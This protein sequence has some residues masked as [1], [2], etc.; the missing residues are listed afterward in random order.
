MNQTT[1]KY[2][3]LQC[4]EMDDLSFV[5]S[6]SSSFD[7]LLKDLLHQKEVAC[8]AVLNLRGQV[9]FSN[10]NH[11]HHKMPKGK[12]DALFS[13]YEGRALVTAVKEGV[14]H[15][16]TLSCVGLRF[17]I[18]GGG[19]SEVWAVGPRRAIG[20]Y[21]RAFASFH[22]VVLFRTQAHCHLMLPVLDKFSRERLLGGM[23]C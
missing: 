19:P 18:F 9:L 5:G 8:V 6:G 12:E 21:V 22:L 14:S 16:E 4:S 20:L 15:D 23:S 13:P 1:A 2:Q 10:I 7:R 17:R 11:K 3:Y